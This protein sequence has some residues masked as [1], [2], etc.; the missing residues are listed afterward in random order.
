[1]LSFTNNIIV[2]FFQ[3]FILNSK[4]SKFVDQI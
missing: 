3:W 2:I 4:V 1:M